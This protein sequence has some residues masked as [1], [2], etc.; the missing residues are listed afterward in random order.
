MRIRTAVL[1]LA[2]QAA[3]PAWHQSALG[4]DPYFGVP[5]SESGIRSIVMR[6][7][8][9]YALPGGGEYAITYS[10]DETTTVVVR[11]GPR[12]DG[13]WAIDG[14][15]RLCLT[16]ADYAAG[17]DCFLVYLDGTTL[18]LVDLAGRIAGSTLRLVDLAGRIAGETSLPGEP[19]AWLEED[20]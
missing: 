9:V 5:V 11:S 15:G 7:H 16:W 18:R 12:F 6:H 8:F 17:P 1:F 13:I 20:G 10:P 2:V 3:L 14:A 19:P 4:Q